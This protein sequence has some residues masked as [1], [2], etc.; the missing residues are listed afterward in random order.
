MT[1]L[2]VMWNWGFSECGKS[3]DK[4]VRRV[5]GQQDKKWPP[6]FISCIENHV[7]IILKG[8]GDHLRPRHALT[9]I[10]SFLCGVGGT[11]SL[12]QSWSS[13]CEG[14]FPSSGGI[15]PVANLPGL[16]WLFGAMCIGCWGLEY[17]FSLLVGYFPEYWV[18][19]IHTSALPAVEVFCCIEKSSSK[20][21]LYSLLSQGT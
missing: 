8:V 14:H 21:K 13:F 15:F 17:L 3:K 10:I 9:A 20:S 11:L 19:Q 2:K 7:L 18:L 12:C 6:Y 1:G 4:G 5:L 16:F